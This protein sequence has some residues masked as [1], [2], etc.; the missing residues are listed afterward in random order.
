MMTSKGTFSNR[1]YS[2]AH[3]QGGWGGG[4]V[5]GVNN[6]IILQYTDI[7][8]TLKFSEIAL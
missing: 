5:G 8:D 3:V 7:T 2:F 1:V 6:C 4:G